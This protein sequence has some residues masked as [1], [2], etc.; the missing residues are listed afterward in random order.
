MRRPKLTYGVFLAVTLLL[1]GASQT[2]CDS[3]ASLY[4]SEVQFSELYVVSAVPMKK[5]IED[6]ET[7]YVPL[8]RMQDEAADGM[9]LRVLLKGTQDRE[10]ND[11]DQSIRPG[12]RIDLQEVTEAKVTS[13]RFEMSIGCIEKQL[14]G[15]AKC[16]TSSDCGPGKICDTSV[17]KGF[18]VA[19]AGAVGGCFSGIETGDVAISHVGYKA[20]TP[21]RGDGVGVA[22]LVDMS[23]SNKGF[24][25]PYPPY[26]EVNNEDPSGTHEDALDGFVDRASD[27]NGTRMNAV[28]T[29]LQNL[30][31]NDKA[32]VF[33]YREY[34]I[35]VI[36]DL[37]AV[38][39]EDNDTKK[40]N[41]YGTNLS[42]VLGDGSFGPLDDYKTKVGG[43]SPLWTAV[44]Q[45]L[46]YME[47][48]PRTQSTKYKHI[49]V[50]NDGPDTCSES[51]SL[52]QCSG[53]C[54]QYST[55]FDTVV[56]KVEAGAYEDR[57]PI[58]FIQYQAKGYLDRDPRQQE[59]ACL[60]GG[61][62]IFIN[63]EDFDQT[64]L[65]NVFQDTARQVRYT[66]GG[67]WEFAIE[68]TKLGQDDS[69]P[70]GWNYGIEGSGKLLS[71]ADQFLVPNDYNFDPS[72]TFAI[73]GTKVDRRVSLR[74]DCAS[75]GDCP[76]DEDTGVCTTRKW[77]CDDDT[78][79]C[80]SA[81]E[82][83]DNGTGGAACGDVDAVV[84]TQVRTPGQPT[85]TKEVSLGD[86]PSFCCD[87]ACMPPLPPV[88]PAELAKTGNTVCFEYVNEKGWRFDEVNQ[89]WVYWAE[90]YIQQDC[91]SWMEL[92]PAIAFGV[93]GNPAIG[94]L[95]WEEHWDCPERLN[96]FP[97]PDAGN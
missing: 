76:G 87:G 17:G 60:T 63:S 37:P 31:S 42:L 22:I 48:H 59:I 14:P 85:E 65:T 36:C 81:S 34:G 18:C 39:D 11:L 55:S 88:I 2:G 33:G 77:W 28:K 38:E 74:K 53:S 69:L 89:V 12:D 16:A 83:A 82:W 92:K 97:P 79:E 58:H 21:S 95:T 5:V 50:I 35:D 7:K 86:L 72:K 29:I 27:L 24:V 15:T 10:G 47:N 26:Y 71:L 91:P 96:C 41:C 1:L 67:Y 94:E 20:F 43:R 25:K 9:I 3:T 13:A 62:H 52:D 64:N 6:G 78:L 51:S 44:D 61:H 46:D 45:A 4:L 80:T 73:D 70:P 75:D 66:F 19:G 90:L 23:G 57:I 56:S 40:D 84:R 8:C 68:L 93:N 32:I 30:N 49:V 54:A